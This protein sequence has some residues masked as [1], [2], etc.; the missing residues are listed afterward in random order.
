MLK[1]RI[2]L[3]GAFQAKLGAK[4][5][6]AFGTDKTRALLAYL[7]T[8][9]HRPH[10]REH[11]AGLLWS[12]Q[13]EKKALH[14]L[15]QSLSTLRKLLK[16]SQTDAPYLNVASDSIQFNPQS[17][18]WIDIVDFRHC[19][20][21]GLPKFH[22]SQSGQRSNIRRLQR[23]LDLYRGNFLDQLFLK[24]SPL[25]D[26]WAIIQRESLMRQY[27]EVMEYLI[28]YHERRG[29]FERACDVA[30]QIVTYLPW[31]E[32]AHQ[33]IMRMLAQSGRLHAAEQQFQTLQ[34]YLHSELNVEPAPKTLS[35]LA[36][37]RSCADQ[38]TALTP[39]FSISKSNIPQVSTI[40]VGRENEQE[41]LSDLLANYKTRLITLTGSGGIGKTRLAI[42]FAREQIGVFNDGVYFVPLTSINSGEQLILSIADALS[43]S[44]YTPQDPLTLLID[45]LRDKE[46]LLVLD[47]FEHLLVDSNQA[48]DVLIKILRKSPHVVMLATSRQPLNLR[49]ENT[50]EIHGMPYPA[51]KEHPPIIAA[52][53]S[54]LQLF[55]KIAQ[56]HNPQFSLREHE[57]GII[58]ICQ[59]VEGVPLGIELS[60][61]WTRGYPVEE[62]ARQIEADLDFLA[63]TMPDIPERHRSIRSVFDHSWK[64]LSETEQEVLRKLT[65]FPG[66]FSLNAAIALTGANITS[67]H[68]LVE[69]SLL[70][71][72][73]EDRYNMHNLL[74][75]FASEKL[76]AH[77][78][79]SSDTHYAHCVYF[80][81][82]LQKYEADLYGPDP[83]PAEKALSQEIENIRSA[84]NYTIQTH[85]L[86]QIQIAARSLARFYDM[87]SWFSEGL[88]AFKEAVSAISQ[89]SS[90]DKKSPQVLGQV[91]A[92]LAW[93]EIQTGEYQKA[94]ERLENLIP[95]LP[96]ESYAE[97]ALIHNILGSAVYEL[98]EFDKAKS[99]FEKSLNLASKNE[100]LPAMAFANNYLGNIAR[101]QGDFKLAESLFT[102]S[103]EQY[104][105]LDDLWGAA[106]VINNL[107]NMAGIN[108]NYAQAEKIFK[109]SLAIRRKLDDKAGIAGC[110]HNLSIIAFFKEDYARTREL[111]VECLSICED[112]GFL[113]GIASTLKHIGD[114][115]KAQGDL[116]AARQRYTKSLA[117][118][119]R[120]GDRRS[121]AFTHNSLGSLAILQEDLSLA[122][123]HYRQ[124]LQTAME[125]EVIPLV[126]DIFIGIATLWMLQEKF[127][128]AYQ[129]LY[130]TREHPGTE[131]QTQDH[132]TE[133]ESQLVSHLTSQHIQ[134][135][136]AQASRHSLESYV[137]QILGN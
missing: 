8:E 31:D 106:R 78:N 27:I 28:T 128:A 39:A 53:Y 90:S 109:E 2:T 24:G 60:A 130:F 125:I 103:L 112:I 113:W 67:L 86:P 98:G 131:S 127:D 116:A 26:E 88:E 62:I 11:L 77:V 12:D 65:V 100:N 38:N 118:S 14:S 16:S 33:T 52:N 40:F 76:N 74:R 7:A 35:L 93:F 79:E 101:N 18:H 70:Q 96:S 9:S 68:S 43:F 58:R 123:S 117:I 132:A 72:V 85:A 37:I 115:D 22:H 94:I 87:R 34:R 99:H 83:V 110:L 55:E 25:F 50:V 66:S 21:K 122:W 32:T 5:L 36:K 107:G 4:T 134:D 92:Q 42:H 64:L 49:I 104:Q 10:R 6:T 30:T 51:E 102:Q 63:S 46:I 135:I 29:E 105:G 56:R 45:H 1:L 13:S 91:T 84:W 73:S 3:F 54:S 120:S 82:Y 119:Q 44:F 61:S 129:L 133:L 71:L 19:V 69:K 80:S 89:V 95:V 137:A 17:N 47:N 59:L 57:D 126:M 108:G 20:E 81:T 23:A 111:R 121:V 48:R 75:Q 114:V 41:M 15:R 136:K 97:R 124:A